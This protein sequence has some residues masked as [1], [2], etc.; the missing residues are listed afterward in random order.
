MAMTSVPVGWARAGKFVLAIAS[1]GWV[2]SAVVG[3]SGLYLRQ[4]AARTVARTVSS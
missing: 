4:R 2:T 3:L 1:V